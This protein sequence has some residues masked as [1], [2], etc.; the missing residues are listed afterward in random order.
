MG[1]LISLPTGLLLES[2]TDTVALECIREQGIDSI[3]NVHNFIQHNNHSTTHL[4]GISKR[5][6]WKKN[7][8][9]LENMSSSY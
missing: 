9:D 4:L 7:E 3:L 8:I 2:D 5:Q 1:K 6:R